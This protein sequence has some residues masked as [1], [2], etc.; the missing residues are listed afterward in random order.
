M[1]VQAFLQWL[2]MTSFATAVRENGVLFPTVEGLHVLACALVVGSVCI[3]DL[4]L[5]GVA[6]FD[7]SISRLMKQVLPVTWIA[8]GCAV[9]T[10]ATL[11]SSQAVDYFHN[12]AFQ[13]KFLLL[14]LLALN[15]CVFHL[16]TCRG[17]RSWDKAVTTPA[18]ARLAGALSLLFW[19]GVLGC[20]RWIGFIADR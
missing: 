11:F 12:I 3:V 6:A 15:M 17:S 19:V 14:S 8:F 9:L 18:A 13:L 10:G 2:Q 7:Q 1:N 5:L 4:R 20:G 16:F